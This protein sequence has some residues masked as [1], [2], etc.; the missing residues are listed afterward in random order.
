MIAEGELDT[1]NEFVVPDS[2]EFV[3]STTRH[4]LCDD[5]RAR[6]TVNLTEARLAVLIADF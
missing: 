2:N 3:H 6:D 1:S 4:V 5:D